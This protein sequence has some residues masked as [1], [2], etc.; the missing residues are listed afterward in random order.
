MANIIDKQRSR[1]EMHVFRE[2]LAAVKLACQVQLREPVRDKRG[3]AF[4]TGCSRHT[5][6][7][8]IGVTLL[9]PSFRHGL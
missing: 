7:I 2:A 3:E 8:N 1:I 5:E 6:D 4:G 9:Q